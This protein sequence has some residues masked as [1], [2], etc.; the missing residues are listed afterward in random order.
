METWPGRGA[1]IIR[2]KGWILGRIDSV[3][4][5]T[6]EYDQQCIKVLYTDNVQSRNYQSIWGSEWTL[7]PSAVSIQE[8]DLICL[9][10]GASYPIISEYY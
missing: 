7:Q 10:Q 8:G 6:A 9:L 1:T 4:E 5:D 3:K 2:G